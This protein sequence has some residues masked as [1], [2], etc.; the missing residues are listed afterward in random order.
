MNEDYNYN[1]DNSYSDIITLKDA[2]NR[3]FINALCVTPTI[4][5]ASMALGVSEK[6]VK[7]F[8]KNKNIDNEHL[9]IMRIRFLKSNQKIIF[10]YANGTKKKINC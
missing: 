2:K 10:K 1:Y 6:C 4:K 8:L 5:E 3:A 7:D 9:G